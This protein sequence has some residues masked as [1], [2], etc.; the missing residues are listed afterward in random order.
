MPS[1]KVTWNR[2]LIVGQKRAFSVEDLAEIEAR[3]L[4]K[5]NWHDLALLSFGLDT[6]LRSSDLLATKVWQIKYANGPI[7]T[8]IARRQRKTRHVVNPVLTPP[9]R[10]YLMKW[11]EVSGKNPL[12]YVFTRT[13]PKDAKPITRAHYADIVKTWA[14]ALGYDSQEFSSHSIRRS[15][16]AHMYWAGEDIALISRLLGHQSIA[17]TIEYLGI[18]QHKA[19]TAALRH[20]MMLGDMGTDLE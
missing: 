20:P 6:M 14:S 12:D 13:K 11:L 8:L 3:L 17:N 19:E 1:K 7:R 5:T 2:G 18:T 9:T 10:R 4:S 16:P 15:K